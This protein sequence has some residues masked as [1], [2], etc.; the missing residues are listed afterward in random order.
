MKNQLMNPQPTESRNTAGNNAASA[1]LRH[2]ANVKQ[3]V[4]IAVAGAIGFVLMMLEFNLP[5]APAFL[6]LNAANLPALLLS[7]TFGPLSGAAV[8]LITNLL[9]LFVTGTGG[10]GELSNFLLGCVFVV[11]A[12]LLYHCRKTLKTALIA[13]IVGAL[14]FVAGGILSNYF[15]MFPFYTTVSGIPMEAIIGMCQEIIPAV[16]SEFKVILLSVTPFNLLK[17]ALEC[18]LTFL[19]YKRIAGLLLR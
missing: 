18:L 16:D 6:K 8:S 1:Q 5:F 9:H 15:I 12:G 17:A 4:S 14:C 7:F 10:V 19:L 13:L 2:S 3:L 11:P